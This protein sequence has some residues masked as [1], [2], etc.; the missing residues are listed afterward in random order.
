MIDDV[1]RLLPL[2]PLTHAV[3]LALLDAD[4]HG[5]GIIKE[6][7]RQTGGRIRPGT[8]TLYTALQRMLDGGLLDDAAAPGDPDDDPR[9]RYYTITAH[10]RAVAL[11]ES[12]RLA[13][14]LQVAVEKSLLGSTDIGEVLREEGP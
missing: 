13:R 8:G 10:G 6:V 1:E 12:R 9:R 3:L 2:T 14:S 5:Y 4:R 11:A 7:D